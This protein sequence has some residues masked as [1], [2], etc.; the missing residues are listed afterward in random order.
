MVKNGNNHLVWVGVLHR[1]N[2][3]NLIYSMGYYLL[4][5]ASNIVPERALLPVVCSEGEAALLLGN[6]G[7][8][9]GL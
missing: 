5:V 1:V 6:G 8:L 2:K 9:P 3:V 7:R 4:V